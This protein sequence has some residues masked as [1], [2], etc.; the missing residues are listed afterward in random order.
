MDQS[1][2]MRKGS[3]I[4]LHGK[5]DARGVLVAFREAVDYQINLQHVDNNGRY[6]VFNLLIDGN[7]VIRINYYA[8]N[9]QADQVK[10]FNNLTHLFDESEITANTRVLGGRDKNMGL[11]VQFSTTFTSHL[12]CT[13]QPQCTRTNFPVEL[14]QAVG[15]ASSSAI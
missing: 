3:V 6:I 11:L 13:Q 5:S 9:Y 7:P 15:K 2:R 1:I 10:L 12:I 4:F 8:P 14:Y